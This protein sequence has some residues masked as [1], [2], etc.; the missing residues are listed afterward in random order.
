VVDRRAALLD[1]A[2]EIVGSHGMRA[3]T[4]RAVD[5]QAGLPVGS[6]SNLFRTREALLLGLGER[7]VERERAMA[8]G[9]R[10][11]VESTAEGVAEALGRFAH[12]A[13]TSGRSVTVARYALL[14]EAAQHPE[15]AGVLVDGANRVDAW[16]LDLVTRAGSS[17]PA[18]DQDVLANFVT[19]MVLHQLALPAADFDPTGRIA[20]LL[21]T[22][23]W[24][25]S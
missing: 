9:G 23:D 4:H 14:V 5:A 17:D 25:S 19:G 10:G 8:E 12:L 15:L 2:L 13:T 22:L 1:A 21:A 7:F 16:A 18:R 3:L 11:E 6:T 24:R 20:A